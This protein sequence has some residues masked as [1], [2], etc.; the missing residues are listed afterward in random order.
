MPMERT[1]APPAS[2]ARPARSRDLIRRSAEGNGVNTIRRSDDC[3]GESFLQRVLRG[4]F[5]W[6]LQALDLA[7]SSAPGDNSPPPPPSGVRGFLGL[8]CAWLQ[9]EY[10]LYLGFGGV[11]PLPFRERS[12]YSKEFFLEQFEKLDTETLIEK[13]ATRNLTDEARSAVI[14]ILNSRGIFDDELASLAHQSKKDQYLRT[15]VTNQCDFCGK[16]LSPIPFSM[17]GQRFCDIDC[18]HTSRLRLAAVDLTEEQV[19]D[20]AKRL[21]ESPC[22]KCSMQGQWPD[23]HETHFIVSMVFSSRPAPKAPLPARHA[24]TETI[25]GQP[26]H[27]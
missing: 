17:D 5:M 19:L 26:C 1:P 9:E 20:R 24:R 25:F 8:T 4:T 10:W 18:F 15:G 23:M 27:A 12:M 13:F 7:P 6:L 11:N 3:S 2:A 21:K 16:G 22:P 14:E